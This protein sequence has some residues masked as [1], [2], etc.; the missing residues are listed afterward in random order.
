MF[1]LKHVFCE[2]EG[3]DTSSFFGDQGTVDETTL[4]DAGSQEALSQQPPVKDASDGKDPSDPNDETLDDP[5]ATGTKSVP[6]G[7]LQEERT[8]RQQAQDRQRELETQNNTLLERMNQILM[9]QQQQQQQTPQ[10]PQQQQPQIPDFIDDPVGHLEGIKAQFRQEMAALQQQLQGTQQHQQATVQHQQLVQAAV[11]QEAQFRETTPDY[12][13][14]VAHFQAVKNAEYAAIGLDDTQ[15]AQQMQRDSTALV[16]IAIQ[17]GKNPAELLYNMAKALR[18]TP[19]AADPNAGQQPAPAK[20]PNTSLSN[21][22]ASGRAP[23]EKGKLS[24]KD[25]ATMPQDEFDKLFDSLRGDS[26]QRPAF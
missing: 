8:K 5:S 20:Q 4:P 10:Q 18:Y 24:A 26:V 14:A 23:D 16:Q 3:L 7:A 1:K 21:L 6:L 25:I 9:L 22:S 11:A 13:A 12:D 2:P 15:R 19:A 17:N